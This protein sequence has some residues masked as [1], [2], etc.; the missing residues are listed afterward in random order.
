MNIETQMRCN[1]P[2]GSDIQAAKEMVKEWISIFDTL[3]YSTDVKINLWCRG[4]SGA[5]LAALFTSMSRYDCIICHIKKDG[6]NSHSTIPAMHNN[7]IKGDTINVVI[8]DFIASGATIKEIIKNISFYRL[9]PPTLDVLI[10]IGA[11]DRFK[12]LFKHTIG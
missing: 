12:E 5:I 3:E 1:Y 11:T 8:D 2:V 9:T 4:S 7:M 6:E 10:A